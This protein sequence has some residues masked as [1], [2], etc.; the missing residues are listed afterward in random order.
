MKVKEKKNSS[1]INKKKI[2]EEINSKINSKLRVPS[3]EHV[4]LYSKFKKRVRIGDFIRPSVLIEEIK[5]VM[6]IPKTL[7]YPILKQMEE[8]GLIQRIN[9]QKYELTNEEK[10]LRIKEINLKLKDLAERKKYLRKE[11][12]L[13]AMEECGLIKKNPNTKFRILTSDCD[14]KIELMG[15]YTFW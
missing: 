5:R 6:K 10:N 4:F 11:R 3:W 13:N 2:K 15:N 7:H 1:K 9:H 12:M 14:K 8:E